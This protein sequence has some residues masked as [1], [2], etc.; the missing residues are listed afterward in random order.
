MVR[1]AIAVALMLAPFAASSAANEAPATPAPGSNINLTAGPERTKELQ[2]AVARADKE[3]FA[4]FFDT[5]DVAK[6]AGMVTDDFEFFHDKHGLIATTGP[7]FVEAMKAKCE[8]QKTGEDFLSKRVLDE[9]TLE[10]FPL[11]NY[12]A[13]EVGVHR[14]YAVIEGQP[15]RLTEVSRFTQVWKDDGGVW[16]LARV[17]SYDHK[18]AEP[19]AK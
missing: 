4:A 16:K 15:D 5:C 18:L 17:L 12:G 7:Q 6:V 9:S 1:I 2:D 19:P 14:F 10:V 11:N 13:V 8:R 3:F